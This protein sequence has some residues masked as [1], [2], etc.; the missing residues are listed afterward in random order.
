M[1]IPCS[2]SVCDMTNFVLDTRSPSHICN[3]L[4][5]LQVSQ[6]FKSGERFLIVGDGSKV[7]VLVLGVVNLCLES[8]NVTLN[9]YH[10]FPSFVMN[11]IFVGQL[12]QK[13]YEFLIKK[14]ILYIIM[15][16]VKL[17]VG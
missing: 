13:N 6:R 2:F 16:G 17:Q 11:V 4:H 12:V 1:I 15:N 8:C 9:N 10:F 5:G 7:P 3:S 14:D